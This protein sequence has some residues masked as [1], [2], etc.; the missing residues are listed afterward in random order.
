MSITWY[1]GM[2]SSSSHALIGGLAGAAVAKGGYAALVGKR[3]SHDQP[4]DRR[5][6]VARLP[7]RHG[8]L[9]IIVAHRSRALRAES[10]RSLVP[11]SAVRLGV[12]RTASATAA[13]TRRR[14]WASSPWLL[15]AAA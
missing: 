2:P 3:L 11:P 9:M 1:Y 4:G 5:L 8:G 13:T 15:F 7:A 12:A 14:P 10:H 6:A